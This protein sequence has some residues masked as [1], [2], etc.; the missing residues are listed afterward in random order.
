MKYDSYNFSNIGRHLTF[1]MVR[2]ERGNLDKVAG[3]DVFE[4]HKDTVLQMELLYEW[5][6]PAGE[7]FRVLATE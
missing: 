7:S 6:R 2:Q 4:N 3:R 1:I 5:E